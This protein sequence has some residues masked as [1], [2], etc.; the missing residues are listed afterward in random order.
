MLPILYLLFLNLTFKKQLLVLFSMLIKYAQES[1]K[2]MAELDASSA[3]AG[4]KNVRHVWS[5]S[6]IFFRQSPSS[7]NW[8][9]LKKFS[10]KI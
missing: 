4:S 7:V 6:L 10:I 8:I 1:F 2:R 9:K 5:Q 3:K